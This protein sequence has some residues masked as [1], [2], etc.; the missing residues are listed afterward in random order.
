MRAILITLARLL[1]FVLLLETGSSFVSSSPATG[2]G[3]RARGSLG[4]AATCRTGPR[5]SQLREGSDLDRTGNLETLLQAVS[6]REVN[7]KEVMQAL[8]TLSS[9]STTAIQDYEIE[10]SWE[11]VFSTQLASGYMPVREVIGF[12]P[13]RSEVTLDTNA[14]P[15]PLGGMRGACIWKG[16]SENVLDFSLSTLLFGPVKV[17][18]GHQEVKSYSFFLAQDQIL[19]ARS[20]A[21]GIALLSR[22]EE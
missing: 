13:S 3:R 16:G 11:L 18:R 6:T 17:E 14:G 5:L 22:Q 9:T 15:I 21:G 1:P 4:S 7:S 2:A 19:A 8:E 20:S 10:G 12:F